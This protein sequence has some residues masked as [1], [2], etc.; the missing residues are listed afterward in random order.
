MNCFETC[1]S[2]EELRIS[3]QYELHGDR[4]FIVKNNCL[5]SIQL[6]SKIKKIINIKKESLKTYAF[7]KMTSMC[8]YKLIY[9]LLYHI[10]ENLSTKIWFAVKISGKTIFFELFFKNPLTKP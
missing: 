8:G 1:N 3:S 10:Y 9:A 7:F 6:L 5:E 4:L 2:L